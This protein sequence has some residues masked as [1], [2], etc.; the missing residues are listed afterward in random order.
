M[1]R[2]RSLNNLLWL[3]SAFVRLKYLYYTRIWGMDI[4]PS[5]TFSLSARFDKNY[6]AGVHIGAQTYVAFEAAILTHDMTRG[7]RGHTRIGRHC[8]I[9]ARSVILPGI[10][11]GDESIVGAGSVVTKDVPPQCVVAGNP[12]VIIRRGI[13]VG[14]Y[15]RF[16]NAEETKAKLV[17]AGA[18]D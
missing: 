3:R 15:G 5:A 16:A 9:G 14:P 4:D 12:A 2:R 7:V 13:A 11:I 6:P 17:A 1:S 18:F 10:V 8:F